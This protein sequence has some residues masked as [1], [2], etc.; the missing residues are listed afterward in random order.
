MDLINILNKF[1][2]AAPASIRFNSKP[3]GPDILRSPHKQLRYVGK[4][5]NIFW[6]CDVLDSLA[7]VFFVQRNIFIYSKWMKW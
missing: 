2:S 1:Y 5:N 3:I 6:V 7:A 4:E